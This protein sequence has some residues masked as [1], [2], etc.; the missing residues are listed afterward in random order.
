[1]K[2]VTTLHNQ[3]TPIHTNLTPS[4]FSMPHRFLYFAPTMHSQKSFEND[5]KIHPLQIEMTEE[6]Y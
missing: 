6:S 1:M 5:K 2:S 3:E 4:Y